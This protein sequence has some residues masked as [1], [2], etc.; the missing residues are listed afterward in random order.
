LRFECR[1]DF[2]KIVL[3][4][5]WFEW[6]Q[7]DAEKSS[8][9]KMELA[10]LVRL[11]FIILLLSLSSLC[12]APSQVEDPHAILEEAKRLAWLNNWYAAKPLFQQAEKLFDEKGD[13]LIRQLPN[14][15]TVSA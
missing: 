10:T 15:N 3:K 7:R 4:Y 12:A 11:T 8:N 5:A 14:S 1:S 13:Q 9:Q 2:H 6:K